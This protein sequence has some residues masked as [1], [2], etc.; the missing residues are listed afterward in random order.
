MRR[1][2][3]WLLSR[4]KTQEIEQGDMDTHRIVIEPT[5]EYLCLTAIRNLLKR[6]RF[7]NLAYLHHSGQINGDEFEKEIQKNPEKYAINLNQELTPGVAE[8]IKDIINKLNEREMSVD[9][10]SELFSIDSR[11]FKQYLEK[12]EQ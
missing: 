3:S 2:V 5:K 4:G 6:N 8:K 12:A 11:N 10:V 9:G 7:L 1:M